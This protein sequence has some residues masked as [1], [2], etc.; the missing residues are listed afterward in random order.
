M[1]TKRARVN[2]TLEKAKKLISKKGK[3]KTTKRAYPEARHTIW[4]MIK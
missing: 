2:K 1:A 4:R 3:K